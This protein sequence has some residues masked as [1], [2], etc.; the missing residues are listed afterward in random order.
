MTGVTRDYVALLD[1]TYT[2][3]TL[4]DS[5]ALRFAALPS[6]VDSAI[7]FKRSFI[8]RGGLVVYGSK[9]KLRNAYRQYLNTE[10]WAALKTQLGI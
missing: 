5:K 7:T 2:V 3:E 6:E 4:G 1:N 9:D 10:A 8:E